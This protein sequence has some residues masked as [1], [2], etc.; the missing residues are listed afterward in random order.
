M[1]SHDLLRLRQNALHAE[2]QA[3]YRAALG[4]RYHMGRSYAQRGRLYREAAQRD[5][6][7]RELLIFDYLAQRKRRMTNAV[8]G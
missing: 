4:S 2:Q 1:T 6:A 3:A 8:H 5:R 7:E